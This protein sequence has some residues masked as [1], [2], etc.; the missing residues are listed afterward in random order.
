[1]RK[2]KL[3]ED[4]NL[5]ICPK[6][7]QFTDIIVCAASCEDSR[8][9]EAYR[10][11][12]SLDILL[13]YVENHPNYKLVGELMAT[14]KTSKKTEKTLWIMNDENKIE[15]ITEKEVMKNPQD[16]MDVQIWDKPTYKYEVIIKLKRVRA[17]S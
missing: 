7:K 11:K 14:K 13:N 8:Y 10:E 4:K 3:R 9:C 12:I 6:S 2:R 15:E 1:M 17:E 16:Y 5:I